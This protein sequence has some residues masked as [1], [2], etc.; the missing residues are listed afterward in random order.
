MKT[1]IHFLFSLF[2]ISPQQ[3]FFHGIIRRI[4]VSQLLFCRND[5][6]A[7]VMIFV[8]VWGRNS[9][10]SVTR[11]QLR[12]YVAG[13]QRKLIFLVPV[14]EG[15]FHFFPVHSYR[16]EKIH[17]YEQRALSSIAFYS[18]QNFVYARREIF[19]RDLFQDNRLEFPACFFCP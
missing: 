18:L 11:N 13:F 6:Y 14:V 12:L 1:T 16:P 8:V 5:S 7:L 15:F 19:C 2:N 10:A 4:L 3:C 17:Y 9:L